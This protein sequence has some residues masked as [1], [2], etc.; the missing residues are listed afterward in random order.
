MRIGVR[1]GVRTGVAAAGSLR[2][3]TGT[4]ATTRAGAGGDGAAKA[5][6]PRLRVDRRRVVGFIF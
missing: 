6:A 3:M 2:M 4:T 5:T 1:I